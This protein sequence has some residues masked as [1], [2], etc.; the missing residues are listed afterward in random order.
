[1]KRILF[2]L[3]G[4]SAQAAMA[5]PLQQSLSL[6]SGVEHDTNPAMAATN[7]RA[8][9][10][11]KVTPG[12]EAKWVEGASTWNATAQVAVE[13]SSDQALSIDREDPSLGVGWTHENPRGSTAIKATYDQQ[14]TSSTE[15]DTQGGA[16]SNDTRTRY[17]VEGG[18]KHA[19]T[20]R[21]EAG[22]N[23]THEDNSYQGAAGA[24][25]G[26]TDYKTTTGMASL[27]YLLNERNRPY[28]KA[29]VSQ[30]SPATGASSK[31]YTAVA[32]IKSE[33]SEA[34]DLDTNFGIAQMDG[35]T[36]T[37][38]WNGLLSL[39]HEGERT[40]AALSYARASSASGSSGYTEADEVKASISYE[41]DPRSD[42]GADARLTKS[43]AQTPL[44]TSSL[45]L[46]A[47]RELLE[48]LS[49]RFG[50]EY[51][52]QKTSSDKA[53]GSVWSLSLSY[54]MPQL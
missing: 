8:V 30:Y 29:G 44:T 32:G 27:E 39:S 41:L 36:D 40:K 50:Y 24:T 14:S 46:W 45:G 25:S 35:T 33:L 12:Y 48:D 20:D 21:V 11:Y 51:K 23:L 34:L 9:T 31:L 15:A 18:W 22:V 53:K 37:T 26:F 7:A 6:D 43:Y 5:S 54:D 17:G 2:G 52:Q 3:L 49:L 38:G 47:D 16:G 28:T 42:L 1:V 10:R 4:L 13:R 19:V